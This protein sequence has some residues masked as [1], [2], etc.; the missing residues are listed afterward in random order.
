MAA[1]DF[2]S[3]ARPA[4]DSAGGLRASPLNPSGQTAET[5]EP[6]V[7]GNPPLDT[8]G[9]PDTEANGES[10]SAVDG[11]PDEKAPARE[12]LDYYLGYGL[13]LVPARNKIPSVEW[14]NYQQE[15]PTAESLHSW[16]GGRHL[17]GTQMFALCGQVSGWTVLDCDTLEAEQWWGS[18]LGIDVMEATA[19]SLSG[20]GR[21]HHF[22]FRLDPERQQETRSMKA[23]VLQWDLRGEGGGV[24]VPPSVWVDKEG[25]P[26]PRYR[27][28]NG[29]DDALPWPYPEIPTH[30]IEPATGQTVAVSPSGDGPSSLAWLLANPGSGG[31]NNWVTRVLGHFAKHLRYE[32][33]YKQ[34]AELIYTVAAQIPSDHTYQRSEFD[35]TVQ[36]VWRKERSKWTFGK[37]ELDNGFLVSNGHALLT[38]CSQGK[39][40]EDDTLEPW[41]NFNMTAAAAVTTADGVTSYVVDIDRT[42]EGGIDQLPATVLPGEKLGSNDTLNK[43]MASRRLVF[44]TPKGDRAANMRNGARLQLYLEAQH[45]P[46]HTALPWMGYNDLPDGREVYVTEQGV[47]TADGLIPTD[48]CGLIPDP[49]QIAMADASW[50]YG[51]EYTIE[52]AQAILREVLTFHDPVVCAL[53]GAVWALAPIK[54]AVMKASSLFPHLAVVAPSEAGK[55]NGYFDL[56]LQANGRLSVGGTYTPASLRDD[57]ARHRGGF[58]WIDDPA[59]ID[60]LG[61]LLRAAAGEGVHTR[62]GGANWSE[63]IRTHL[64]APIVLSAEGLDMLSERAMADRT[65]RFEVPSP[66]DRLS[67]RGQYPQWDDIVTLQRVVGRLSRVAG[68]YVQSAWRHLYQMG[69]IDGLRHQML[70]LR[71]GSGRQAEK[72]AAVRTGARVLAALA[73]I[74]PTDEW[75]YVDIGGWQVG[76]GDPI[77]VVGLVDSWAIGEV[78]DSEEKRVQRTGPYMVEVVI[79]AY[80]AEKGFVPSMRSAPVEPVWMDKQG[81]LRVNVQGLATWWQRVAGRRQDRSRAMQLGSLN[82][83]VAESKQLDMASTNPVKGRRYK[84]LSNEWSQSVLE[85]AGFSYDEALAEAKRQIEADPTLGDT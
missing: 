64:V 70:E 14:R 23:G 69:G 28:E 39:A 3:P 82:A 56:M 85:R 68:H 17:A 2:D 54:G 50:E 62:K 8:A 79:P 75:E 81:T 60:D 57:L 29:L 15:P 10:V 84:T 1:D 51:F 32:D 77:D 74:R 9:V 52:Q 25:R 27:W 40:Q 58:V 30:T 35:K 67:R 61:D 11:L 76:G 16:F 48:Q 55:T 36:S 59:N 13:V 65:V 19:R 45:P 22:W 24:I 53:F 38:M 63:V 4:K 66:V 31:R 26:G 46:R 72:I 34:T 33:G 18:I 6:A 20:S 37:P 12:W 49:R 80:L 71:L 42:I 43:W 44:L 47:I 83:L 7:L 41:S 5:D 78:F 21:G 73:G